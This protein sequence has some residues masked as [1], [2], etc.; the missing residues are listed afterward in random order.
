M[1]MQVMQEN[2]V[3]NRGLTTA[4]CID[5]EAVITIFMMISSLQATFEDHMIRIYI[6]IILKVILKLVF[7]QLE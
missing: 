5:T 3:P 4:V 6:L 7:N 2:R 1:G